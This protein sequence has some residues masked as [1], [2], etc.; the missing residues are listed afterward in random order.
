MA[1]ADPNPSS[2]WHS[3]AV[4]LWLSVAAVVIALFAVISFAAIRS[5]QVQQESSARIAEM[6]TK[7]E[8]AKR[9]AAL[10]TTAITKI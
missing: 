1:V 8:R 4:R 5:N 6:D 10:T 7:L 9:W 2:K 3:V